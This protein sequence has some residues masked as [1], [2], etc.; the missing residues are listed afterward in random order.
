MKHIIGLLCGIMIPLGISA[1]SDFGIWASAGAEKKIN[2]NL[3]VEIEGEF[4]SR[5]N[6]KTSDRW[7]IG[8]SAE[9]KLYKFLKTSAGYD[10]LYDNNPE[11]ISYHNNGDYNNRRLS[12]WGARHRFHIDLTGNINFNRFCLSLRER[13]Q[14][15]Y[16]PETKTQRYDY[17]NEYWEETTVASKAKNVLRSRLMLEY[18]F[19]KIDLS[20]Y[21]SIELY[22]AWQTDKIR[23]T[24][25]IDKSIKKHHVIGLYYRYQNIINNDEDNSDCHILGINYKYKF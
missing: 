7:T 9:Y 1:Q 24:I 3:E 5:N 21:T 18:D 19:H 13:W 4:R 20:P 11:K 17:D 23:Y 14:Y 25:G 2:K 12:Y 10:L 8:A 6:C 16:R 22:N 15:T